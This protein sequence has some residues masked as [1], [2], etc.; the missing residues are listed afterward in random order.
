MHSIPSFV[1]SLR[2]KLLK[3]KKH[4]L[5]VNLSI[6]FVI[7]ISVFGPTVYKESWLNPFSTLGVP[8]QELHP[9][10]ISMIGMINSDDPSHPLYYTNKRKIQE[11]MRCLE[12]AKPLSA[13][14]QAQLSLENQKIKYFTLH[15][16][17]S[18]YHTEED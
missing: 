10:A 15:R 8:N 5:A 17:S 14:E 13:S 6:V 1:F 2:M 9:R 16:E 7:V 12:R 11:L 4:K 3:L 18:R